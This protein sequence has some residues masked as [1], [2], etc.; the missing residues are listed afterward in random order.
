M[1]EGRHVQFELVIMNLLE[2]AIKYSPP[3]SPLHLHGERREGE[4]LFVLRDE[5]PGIPPTE[6]ERIFDK[7]YR[8]EKPHPLGGTGLGLAICKGIVEE[9]RGLIGVL[10]APGGGAEFWFSVPALSLSKEWTP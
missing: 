6:V 3:D 9:H 5:G 2:N 7:F 4:I 10:N 8:A 1:F